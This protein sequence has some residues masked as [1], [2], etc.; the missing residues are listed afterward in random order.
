MILD[1]FRSQCRSRE[2]LARDLLVEFCLQIDINVSLC[3]KKYAD[4]LELKCLKNAD[5]VL[6]NCQTLIMYWT[7]PTEPRLVCS[8]ARMTPLL[9][10]FVCTPDPNYCCLLQIQVLLQLQFNLH[11]TITAIVKECLTPLHIKSLL[12]IR[13]LRT[14]QK[15][16]A[17]AQPS[18]LLLKFF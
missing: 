11:G 15:V 7:S 12:K 17:G 10:N 1:L 13:K 2:K 8:N 18:P 6:E 5:F 9:Q 3:R 4:N 14:S 16:G